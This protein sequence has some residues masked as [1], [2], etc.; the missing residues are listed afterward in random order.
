MGFSLFGSSS[1]SKATTRNDSITASDNALVYQPTKSNNTTTKTTTKL[2]KGATLT[3]HNGLSEEQFNQGLG[4]L[5]SSLAASAAVNP[6][7]TSDDSGFQQAVLMALGERTQAT[8]DL[9]VDQVQ[10]AKPSSVNKFLWWGI[11]AV[12]LVALVVVFSSKKK[13]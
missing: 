13:K 3:V 12:V 2:G 9:V 11:G 6:V 4:A 7:T 8:T 10:A 1:D 5:A